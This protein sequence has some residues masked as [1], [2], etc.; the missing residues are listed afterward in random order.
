MEQDDSQQHAS[1]ACCGS[2]VPAWQP[3]VV[4]HSPVCQC[5]HAKHQDDHQP[6]ERG[7]LRKGILSWCGGPEI[8][9]TH[10]PSSR[11]K[12]QNLKQSCTGGSAAQRRQLLAALLRACVHHAVSACG[13]LH[14]RLPS[15]P[16]EQHSVLNQCAEAGHVS[17]LFPRGV[18][19]LFIYGRAIRLAQQ[20]WALFLKLERASKRVASYSQAAAVPVVDHDMC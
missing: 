5:H 12:R 18:M 1:L 15:V 10:R 6:V 11:R 20:S 17:R 16:P 7:G 2:P 19:K 14:H 3:C 4:H 8:S 13:G 9:H